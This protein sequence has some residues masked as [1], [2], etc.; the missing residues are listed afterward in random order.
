MEAAAERDGATVAS[1]ESDKAQTTSQA[2]ISAVGKAQ[3]LAALTRSRAIGISS[4]RR[5]LGSI[6]IDAS[7]QIVTATVI[8]T[9][10]RIDC[11]GRRFIPAGMSP[12]APGLVE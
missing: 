3:N 5:R 9:S 7:G 8:I 10:A 1:C 4:R 12:P 11:H 6:W 2:T